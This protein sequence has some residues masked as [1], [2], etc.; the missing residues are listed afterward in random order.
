MNETTDLFDFDEPE[1]RR[2]YEA[3]IPLVNIVFLMLI[4]FLLA[5][6]IAPTDPVDVALPTGQMNDEGV[7]EVETLYV[8]N[9]GFIWLDDKP[10]DPQFAA[11]MLRGHLKEAGTTS[12]A[13]KSDADAPADALLHLMEGLRNVGIERVQ[14]VTE[15]GG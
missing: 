2:R 12:L 7:A 5:G 13:I 3:M 4:F 10:M 1:P 11:Y 15:K 6:T 14:I 8:D 9:E